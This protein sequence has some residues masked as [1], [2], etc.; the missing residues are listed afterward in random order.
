MPCKLPGMR[1]RHIFWLGLLQAMICKGM[2]QTDS[3]SLWENSLA[4]QQD[5]RL[6]AG[7]ILKIADRY[8]DAMRL[9]EA[10]ALLREIAAQAKPQ[11]VHEAKAYILQSRLAYFSDS[12]QAGVEAAGHALKVAE[13][14][15]LPEVAAEARLELGN[16]FK[17]MGQPAISRSHFRAAYHLLSSG[18]NTRGAAAALGGLAEIYLDEGLYFEAVDTLLL[19]RS[20]AL[21]QR[22]TFLLARIAYALSGVYKN[23]PE[24]GDKAEA[25]TREGMRF[26]AVAGSLPL[27]CICTAN[28][29][30]IFSDQNKPDSARKYL[31]LAVDRCEP[32]GPGWLTTAYLALGTLAESDGDRVAQRRWLERALA[33]DPADASGTY[34]LHAVEVL[35]ELGQLE[36][37]LGNLQAA[38]NGLQK[39][40]EAWEGYR[41]PGLGVHLFA[42][43]SQ[44]A[45]QQG[46]PGPALA[47]FKQSVAFRDSLFNE[48]N[49][50]RLAEAAITHDFEQ[51]QALSELRMAQEQANARARNRNLWLGFA[52]FLV[53]VG[54]AG[55]GAFYL[56]RQRQEQR[57]NL[58]EL[59]YLRAQMNPHFV[60]NCL[61]SIYRYIKEKDTDTAAFYLQKFSK[62]LRL[63]L[64]N[65]RTEKITLAKDLEALQ[66]YVEIEA[67]RFKDKL[68]FQ[69]E[70][71]PAIDPGFVQ[72]PGMLIQPHVE[73]AIW[74]GLMHK[75]AGGT[76]RV[77]VSQPTDEQLV[78]EIADDGVGRVFSEEQ[79]KEQVGAHKSL[80]TQITEDRIKKAGKQP[81]GGARVQ[82]TDLY[83][84]DGAALG[85]RVTL[86]IP[87]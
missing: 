11:P 45:E 26:S 52:A 19:S 10:R 44:L 47:F 15:A 37:A 12:L 5:R 20:M 75:E 68:R 87:I 85:T 69:M 43:L 65:S 80:G 49:T 57:S 78:V 73:N 83:S 18:G 72:V 70:V 55:A 22:D 23:L 60:F 27:Y 64:E 9:D 13:A 76:I 35:I 61:N 54:A 25:F 74:H 59:A 66:L 84:Y 48:E 30:Q 21:A 42:S 62:L 24:Y 7:L 63:V 16:L 36:L 82:V 3:L 28:L 71:D 81:R 58:L 46:K 1:L 33:S 8:L 31:L 53:L 17:R 4:H 50:R 38:E 79:K 77:Q 86:F 2:A 32:L 29:G 56:Y 34:S 40:R 67:L 39:A 6:R 51:K 14:N 41:H